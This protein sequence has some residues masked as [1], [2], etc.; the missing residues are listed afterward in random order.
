[1]KR[2]RPSSIHISLTESERRTLRKQA[3]QNSGRIAE[4][5]RY[6]LLA[7]KGKS[8][9]EIA[10]LMDSTP[11]TIYTW[12]KRYQRYGVDGLQDRPRPGRPRK[13][14]FLVGIVQAQAGQS[15]PCF[16]YPLS[17]WTVASLKRHLESRF[18]VRVSAST[19]RRALRAAGFRW[20]RPQLALPKRRDPE[21]GGSPRLTFGKCSRPLTASSLPKMRANWSGCP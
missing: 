16:G 8:V 6:V 4:R 12:L 10:E 3:R 14:R 2:G 18:G 9:Y 5:I 11:Q 17:R 15:P 7:D 20:G 13:E 1:M 19:V 21:A